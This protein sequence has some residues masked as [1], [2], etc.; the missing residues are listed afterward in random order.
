L[1]EGYVSV[2]PETYTNDSLPQERK[3]H[4]NPE[5]IVLNANESIILANMETDFYTYFAENVPAPGQNPVVI[6]DVTCP[7]QGTSKKMRRAKTKC[8][9]YTKVAINVYFHYVWNGKASRKS[10][11]DWEA[12]VQLQVCLAPFKLC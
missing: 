7:G 6:K 4:G 10:K 11:S 5:P 1:P 12:R 9:T 8:K 3:N 2:P